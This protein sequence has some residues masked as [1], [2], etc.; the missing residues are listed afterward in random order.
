M[1]TSLICIALVCRCRQRHSF[2]IFI[3]SLFSLS[4]FS[5]P[6]S[7]L[8]RSSGCRCSCTHFQICNKV[9]C[10]PCAQALSEPAETWHNRCDCGRRD[11]LNVPCGRTCVEPRVCAPVFALAEDGKQL[12][13]E[14]VQR[15]RK[16]QMETKRKSTLLQI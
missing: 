11:E 16:N 15:K 10:R 8:R 5:L 2:S 9:L 13:G 4:Q 14:Y 1:L 6:S 3:H 7:T 12:S